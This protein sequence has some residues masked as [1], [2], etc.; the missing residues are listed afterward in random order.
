MKYFVCISARRSGFLTGGDCI[1]SM[2]I[3][4]PNERIK[5][6]DDINEL[7]K[8]ATDFFFT[9]NDPNEYRSTIML[10]FQKLDDE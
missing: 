9:K 4:H 8:A 6:V 3:E 1:T 2:V 5:D 10:S 7:E